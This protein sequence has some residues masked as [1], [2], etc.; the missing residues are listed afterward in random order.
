MT[1]RARQLGFSFRTWGGARPGAG[2][3]PKG[4]TAGVSHLRRPSLSRHHPLHVTLRVQRGVASL[5]GH[6][7]FAVVRRALAAGKAQFGFSL[8]HFSVQR[9]H[10]HLIAEAKDRRALSRGIQGISIRVARAVNRRL[11]RT[12]RL[13]ADRYHARTLK[14]PRSVRLA[15]R[16]VLLNIRK[17]AR[18]PQGSAGALVER[19]KAPPRAP[20]GSAGALVERPKEPSAGFV[21]ACSSAPWFFDFSR[22]LELAF[23]SREAR[24]EW[25][26]ASGSGEPPVAPPGSWLLRAGWKRAGAFDIDDTPGP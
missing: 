20:Q 21:D 19:P 17:H 9:D 18:A 12:G 25:A 26:R 4:R 3:P 24:A 5:R 6:S 8:V 16:Y 2:R 14:T 7:L 23:G 1:R 10:L 13:F 11:E 15:L 22:P